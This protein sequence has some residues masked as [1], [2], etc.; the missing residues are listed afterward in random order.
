MLWR[1]ALQDFFRNFER[2]FERY[3]ALFYT[4]SNQIVATILLWDQI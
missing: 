2:N 4:V 3:V 1:F